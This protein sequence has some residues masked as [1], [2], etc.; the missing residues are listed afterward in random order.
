MAWQADRQ[1]EGRLASGSMK[2]PRRRLCR[3]SMLPMSHLKGVYEDSFRWWLVLAVP[4]ARHPFTKPACDWR[5]MFSLWRY[6]FGVSSDAVAMADWR[7]PIGVKP[8]EVLV[9]GHSLITQTVRIS[10][11]ETSRALGRH[12]ENVKA[13]KKLVV[14][15]VAMILSLLCVKAEAACTR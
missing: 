11:A 9:V 4:F 12:I 8:L 13:K 15:L 7:A 14:S 10:I 1:A 6:Q 2:N 3:C 5:C